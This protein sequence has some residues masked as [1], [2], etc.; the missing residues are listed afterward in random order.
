MYS[1]RSYLSVNFILKEPGSCGVRL[2][3]DLNQITDMWEQSAESLQ[4]LAVDGK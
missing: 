2:F 1:P 3:Y 4:K